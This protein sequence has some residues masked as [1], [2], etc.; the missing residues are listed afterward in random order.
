MQEPSAA[1]GHPGRAAVGQVLCE[2]PPR[3]GPPE[4][5]HQHYGEREEGLHRGE[6]R[7]GGPLRPSALFWPEGKPLHMSRP[8]SPGRV[9]ER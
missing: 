4:D 9:I 8:V 3:R 2:D 7:P 1:G 6:Q 5:E